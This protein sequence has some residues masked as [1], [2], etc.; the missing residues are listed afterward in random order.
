[1]IADRHT[2]R[3]RPA[4]RSIALAHANQPAGGDGA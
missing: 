1:M 2:G 4:I 3:F